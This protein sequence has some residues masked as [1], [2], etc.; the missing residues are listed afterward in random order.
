MSQNKDIA[1]LFDRMADLIEIQGGDRFRVN[2]YRRAGRTVK[3]LVEDVAVVA[4]EDRLGALPG[5][6]K[7]TAARIRE[8][9]DTGR[10]A[11]HDELLADVPKGLPA[12]L[13]IP[14]LGPKKVSLAWKKLQVASIEDLKRA[15]ESGALADLPG[16][17]AKSVE[18]IRQGID[19]LERSA[20]RIP[21]GA[22]LP[23]AEALVAAV[24]AMKGVKR[25]SLAG[26]IRRGCETVGDIDI[27]AE[28][29]EGKPVVEAFT[30]LAG[31]TQVL[32]AG[33]TKGSVLVDAGS[34]GALQVDLRVV[35]G[36]SFGAALQYF[37]GSKE[38]NVRL[39]EIAVKKNL[40]LNEYRLSDGEQSVAGETEESIYR[41]L[42]VTFV[43]PELR[44]DRGEIGL[45]EAPSLIELGDIRADLHMHTTAS[46]GKCS[47]LEMA[48]AARARGYEC[49]A[50]T[51][52][53]RSSAVANGLSIERME[54]QIRDVREANKQ[55]DGITILV[56]C[57]CDILA[58]GRLD[59][60]DDLLAELDV[61]IASVHSAL[62][63]ERTKITRR[64]LAAI[65]S[66]HVDI[67]GH[68]TG[69]LLNR[70]EPMDL[71][72]EAVIKTA[73]ETKTALE[74][75]A[76]WKR[77]DLK[78]LHVRQALDAGATLSIN[79]DSH[80]TDQLD[81]MRYGIIT[82]RRGWA[83]ADR[84]INTWSLAKLTEWLS[85]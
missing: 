65:E 68:P 83:T 7:A 48:E 66:E 10:I 25:V 26:S 67:L 69:R 40:T 71:N 73:V 30:R 50:I 42:D 45:E 75:N 18:Q 32:A 46:D 59:Y 44:E 35:P 14:G 39:R 21:Y 8:F 61:V 76:S 9:L 78:D 2:S 37:T 41:K 38:H 57:E 28:C 82:A 13:E 64:V 17:G 51:D 6:G 47:I 56:G 29:G 81:Q 49:M 63:Q 74:I 54:Q 53:T 5:I 43:P 23:I 80:H 4:A 33:A 16:L 60:P 15:I 11:A 1:A 62:G 52:H 31:V 79:T 34:D 58:D 84:V 12:L 36:E 24:R 77:L 70:R 19:F 27:L 22:A 55:I 85:G 3:D 20:G 72:M